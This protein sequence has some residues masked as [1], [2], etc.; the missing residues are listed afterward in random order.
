MPKALSNG[1]HGMRSRI[2]VSTQLR[3]ARDATD[4][5]SA[6]QFANIARYWRFADCCQM[7]AMRPAAGARNIDR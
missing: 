1:L 5:R 7:D 6:Q 3:Q 4:A 2:D